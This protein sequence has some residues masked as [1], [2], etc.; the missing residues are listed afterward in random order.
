M[1]SQHSIHLKKLLKHS[2]KFYLR[3]RVLGF[4]EPWSLVHGQTFLRRG[5]KAGLP[6]KTLLREEVSFIM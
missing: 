6:I 4:T 5:K 3:R 1:K 2:E